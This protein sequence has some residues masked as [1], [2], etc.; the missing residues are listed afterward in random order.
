MQII[1][2]TALVAGLAST[3]A[4]TSESACNTFS[5]TITSTVSTVTVTVSSGAEASPASASIMSSTAATS[6][7]CA[8]ELSISSSTTANWTTTEQIAPSTTAWALSES[9]CIS[10]DKTVGV[11]TIPGFNG[12]SY[13]VCPGAAPYPTV[14]TITPS[15]NATADA[16]GATHSSS[17]A[18]SPAGITNATTAAIGGATGT[19]ALAP[20]SV[21]TGP[22]VS[23]IPFSAG[24]AGI[25][26]KDSLVA[27]AGIAVAMIF[28]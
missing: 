17:F 10:A 11:N 28:L 5:T 4:A 12:T 6:S 2:N 24:A 15:G 13:L 19:G 14:S 20:T 1:Y 9:Q 23:I 25:D 3:T 16:V 26:N 7:S 27:L 18:F 8:T 21:V 22:T